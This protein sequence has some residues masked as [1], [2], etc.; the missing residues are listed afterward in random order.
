[1]IEYKK[2]LFKTLFGLKEL[3]PILTGILLLISMI[4]QLGLF[5]NFGNF[6]ENDFVGVFLSNFIGSISA[7][8]VLNSYI[9]ADSIGNFQDNILVITVFL[10]SWVTVGIIQL[11]AEIYFLGKR[12]AIIRNLTSFVFAMIGAYL[13]Y[14][15]MII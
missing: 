3:L 10:I 14:F 11:P 6:L 15:L 5:E 4:T 8:N 13:V 12:F 9:I 2:N 7:G 1:M